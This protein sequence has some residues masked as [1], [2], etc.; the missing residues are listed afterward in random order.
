MPSRKTL[1][2]KL[3]PLNAQVA[4]AKA[5]IEAGIDVEDNANLLKDIERY[6]KSDIDIGLVYKT[7]AGDFRPRYC[8]YCR[9]KYGQIHKFRYV[10]HET[11]M[12][13]SFWHGLKKRCE[14]AKIFDD[15]SF[16]AWKD[17]IKR[18]LLKKGIPSGSL[19]LDT[20]PWRDGISYA[21]WCP[22]CKITT[23]HWRDSLYQAEQ[24]FDDKI[25]AAINR[26]WD[27][28]EEDEE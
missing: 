11:N 18:H 25:E 19:L 20:L 4:D 3:R 26:Y 1:F 2:D 28:Q 13:E 14:D 15:P 9:E 5:A 10:G 7:N 17:E 27:S 22:H 21:M 23:E 6:L 8:E 24:L 16:R 12:G